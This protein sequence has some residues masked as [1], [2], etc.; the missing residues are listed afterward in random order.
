MVSQL[1]GRGGPDSR[2]GS[3]RR[4]FVAVDIG[5]VVRKEL[6]EAIESVAGDGPDRGGRGDGGGLRWIDAAIWHVTLQF[7]GPVAAGRVDDARLA[8]A[9]GAGRI[10]AFTAEFCG[11]GAFPSARRARIVWIGTGEGS[12]SLANLSTEVQAQTAK[13]GFESESRKFHPHV[14]VARA[15][16]PR[17]VSAML[18]SL[19]LPSVRMDVGELTLFES[20]LG[21]SSARYE[22][23]DVFPLQS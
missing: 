6:A 11:A 20:H 3:E 14:T 7:L 12:D 13:R 9:F 19:H 10:R 4:L 1:E 17:D 22:V 2:S 15:K 5:D 21:T 18:G 16:V 23:V 8:C